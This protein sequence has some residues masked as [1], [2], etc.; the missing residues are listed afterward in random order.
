MYPQT[1]LFI[2]DVSVDDGWEGGKGKMGVRAATCNGV[3]EIGGKVG[4]EG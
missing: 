3:M 2:C 1:V 4:R